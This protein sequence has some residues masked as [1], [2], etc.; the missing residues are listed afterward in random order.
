MKCPET[1]A[2]WFTVQ[3]DELISAAGGARVWEVL[4]V[5][6][7]TLLG[8]PGSGQDSQT[9]K[10]SG[11]VCMG[12]HA[13]AVQLGIGC[14]STARMSFLEVFLWMWEKN[15]SSLLWGIVAINVSCHGE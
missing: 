14:P 9:Q 15:P 1:P 3:Q 12:P 5:W 10:L 7:Q 13:E 8:P 4:W 6:G 2:C 11:S